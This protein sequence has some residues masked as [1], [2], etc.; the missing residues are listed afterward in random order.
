[1]QLQAQQQ[2]RKSK[3]LHST[4]QT[5]LTG[6]KPLHPFGGFSPPAGLFRGRGDHENVDP[7]LMT[8]SCLHPS[9]W[10]VP[11]PHSSNIHICHL[12]DTRSVRELRSPKGSKPPAGE[13]QGCTLSSGLQ[14]SKAPSPKPPPHNLLG[15]INQRFTASSCLLQRCCILSPHWKSP[16]TLH[17]PRGNEAGRCAP[18]P[19]LP[20]CGP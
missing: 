12:S 13:C 7:T 10:H 1:M 19:G 14:E 15:S 2:V 11:Q 6:C 9:T 3:A 20:A 18:C 5:H 17:G 4:Q 16:S 8:A